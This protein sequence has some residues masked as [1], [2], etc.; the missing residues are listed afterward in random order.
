MARKKTRRSN[1]A[2]DYSPLAA[3]LIAASVGISAY[4]GVKRN[5]GSIGW[6]LWRAAMGG[7]FPV[8]T[9][10]IAIAQGLGTPIQQVPIQ[11]VITAPAS[12]PPA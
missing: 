1:P 9:P 2:D 7:I 5:N 12:P 8:V 6:G 10:A 3:A 11:V 4:H